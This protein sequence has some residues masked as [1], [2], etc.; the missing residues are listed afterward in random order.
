M[1]LPLLIL[2][3]NRNESRSPFFSFTL[4]KVR[5]I[6]NYRRLMQMNRECESLEKSVD[7][8]KELPSLCRINW[9]GQTRKTLGRE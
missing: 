9:V 3:S 6:P 4:Q 1:R 7:K 5:L 2:N 8:G